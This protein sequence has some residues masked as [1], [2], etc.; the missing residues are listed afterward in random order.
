[1]FKFQFIDLLLW[2]GSARG[3]PRGE[4]VAALRR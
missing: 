1:M 4:A 3:F 2:R